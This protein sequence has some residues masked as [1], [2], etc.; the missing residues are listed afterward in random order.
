VHG[1]E[2]LPPTA[3]PDHPPDPSKGYTIVDH[4][5]GV[6]FL[7]EGAYWSMAVLSN[8]PRGYQRGNGQGP[9]DQGVGPEPVSKTLLIIDAPT[10]FWRE[11]TFNAAMQELLL[12]S[13]ASTISDMLYSHC[14][15]DHIGNA[16]LVPKAA[17]PGVIKIH[18]STPVCDRLAHQQDSRRP[19]PTNCYPGNFTLPQFGLVIHSIGDGHALGNRAIYHPRAKV[20]MYVDIVFPGWSMFKELAQAEYVPEFYEA[21]EK[22][23]RYDF[24]VYVGGHVTR[25]G[26]RQDVL[27]QIEYVGDIRANAKYALDNINWSLAGTAGTFDP[28]SPNYLNYWYL[29]ELVQG[30]MIATCA[31]RTVAKWSNRLGA[32]DI[33]TPSHC[34]KAIESLQID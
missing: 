11:S 21:H 15:T 12:I 7:S 31:T 10:G 5:D 25:F 24:D 32:V 17:A 2:P 3:L 26:N 28:T 13:G 1:V 22:I 14:H 27:T 33:I 20:L 16:H 4:G 18:A 19:V 6:Y 9:L 23:L 29:W 30:E 8:P 34:F